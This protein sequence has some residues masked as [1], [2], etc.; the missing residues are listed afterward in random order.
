[1]ARDVMHVALIGS[2]GGGTA[3]LGHTDAT[4]LLR[5]IH[6]QL[7][8]CRASIG[9]A[10]FVAVDG[11]K[12]MDRVK[13]L[14]DMATL[15]T[16]E[17]ASDNPTLE[18]PLAYR[19][20]RKGTLQVV[21]DCVARHDEAIAAAITAGNIDGLICIS[22]HTKLFCRTL[23]AA[24]AMGIPVTGS[25]G[26][27]LSQAVALY[28]VTLV[29]NAG[30]SVASTSYSRAISYASSLASFWKRP[31]Q[32]FY[33][34]E[35]HL[36]TAWSSVLCACLPA[37]WGV[38]LAKSVLQTLGF[39]LKGDAR[40]VAVDEIIFVLENWTL[41][42]ACAVTIATSSGPTN[43]R[44]QDL[45]L[46]SLVMAS[47]LAS[48]VCAQSVLSGLLAGWLV[49][50]LTH[51]LLFRCVVAN[52]PATMTNMVTTGATGCVVALLMWPV[53]PI[54]RRSTML[55]RWVITWTIVE[56]PTLF[57]YDQ[58]TMLAR[59][60]AGFAWGCL[61]CYG[62]KVGWYHS[63]FLP[64][65]LIEMELGD[66]SFLGAVDEL[67]LVLVC[68]GV[69]AGVLLA[70]SLRRW[71][72][73]DDDSDNIAEGALCR[74]GLYINILCGD[75]IEVCYPFME[76]HPI[77]NASGYAASGLSSAWLVMEATSPTSVPKSL[78]YVPLPISIALS[79]REWSRMSVACCIAAG[80]P[81][82]ATLLS[83]MVTLS[84]RKRR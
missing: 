15:Y 76:R 52:V 37:F 13:A 30:G 19:S 77:I 34:D 16:V 66:A 75:F 40:G 50:R 39:A 56:A 57:E 1:M 10:C 48:T 28:G 49:R 71:L 38:C 36:D 47:V 42:T 69:C 51:R 43:Q 68:A 33:D 60:V 24:A 14:V 35:Q 27:S 8:S 18:A 17:A 78:A 29:G 25:G 6:E 54:L 22:C 55:V 59:A 61:S 65:I 12:G 23:R 63:Y 31:Y 44:Q 21:N 2:S 74:R 41:P 67:T 83:A 7:S 79:R 58:S 64:T 3:T 81:F 84:K 80:I 26:T 46:S 70:G 20:E 82:A 62:S 32:P 53:A 5:S 45:P 72:K 73:I 9:R 11:G 4:A